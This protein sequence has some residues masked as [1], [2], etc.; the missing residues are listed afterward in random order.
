MAQFTITINPDHI[1]AGQAACDAYNEAQRATAE[2][3]EDGN[4]TWVDLTLAQYVQFVM[5][6]AFE[7]YHNNFKP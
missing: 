7:S 6:S 3:D 4:S 1:P 2:K 5:S